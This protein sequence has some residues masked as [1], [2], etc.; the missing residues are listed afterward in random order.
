MTQD[1]DDTK[2]NETLNPTNIDGQI[3]FT[4][5]RVSREDQLRGYGP[6]SQWEE[7]VLPNA[8][9]LGI[10]A[11]EV[12]RRVI[13]EPATGWDRPKF[14]EA[15]REA[16]KLHRSGEINALLFPRVDRE[17]RFLFSSFPILCEALQSGLYVFFAREG[18]RLDPNDSES[19]S[20]YLRKAEESRAYVETMRTN[21]MQGRKRR[22]ERDA[23]MPTAKSRWA[24]EYH[25]YRRDW[26][27]PPDAHSG[28]YTAIPER[29]PIVTAWVGWILEEGASLSECYRRTQQRFGVE[30]YQF[31]IKSA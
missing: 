17:T 20:R 31:W 15:V 10:Q 8:A 26:G 13:Q 12:Y 16:I 27:R 7:D 21:T 14:E 9:R 24:Y 30:L 6:D 29:V 22:M 28:R 23:M 11:K 1:C 19:L 18:F 25:P 3:A 4:I 2:T 5:I